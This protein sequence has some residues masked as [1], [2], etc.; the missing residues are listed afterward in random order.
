MFNKIDYKKVYK[1]WYRH[2]PNIAFW[3]VLILGIVYTLGG[4]VTTSVVNSGAGMIVLFVGFALSIGFA[5]LTRWIT[6]IR[7]SQSVVVADTL[8][9]INRKMGGNTVSE[10]EKKVVSETK[11]KASKS[12]NEELNMDTFYYGE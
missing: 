7:V 11:E 8:L 9:E 12:K 1:E 4:S 5:F 10:E 3:I 6:S 2:L